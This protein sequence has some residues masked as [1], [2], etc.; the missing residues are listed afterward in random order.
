MILSLPVVWNSDA[1]MVY[2]S[3]SRRT[4][5]EAARIAVTT[6]LSVLGAIDECRLSQSREGSCNFVVSLRA[7]NR[8]M[9]ICGRL[10]F[11]PESNGAQ[12]QTKKL[13]F[14]H[15]FHP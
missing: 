3:P 11:V 9:R 6:S 12:E 14:R 10:R 4:A 8:K 1:A 13:I 15:L 7:L 2:S 5:S